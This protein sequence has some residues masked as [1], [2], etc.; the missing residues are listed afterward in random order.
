[1]KD[2]TNFVSSPS[3]PSEFDGETSSIATLTNQ[4][5]LVTVE[6]EAPPPPP[7]EPM[8]KR[9]TLYTQQTPHTQHIPGL[10]GC[11][12]RFQESGRKSVHRSTKRRKRTIADESAENVIDWWSKYYASVE[13]Q[14]VL[15]SQGPVLTRDDE[16]LCVCVSGEE[17]GRLA[18][19]AHL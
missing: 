12:T 2:Q 6:G 17:Q 13:K 10:H 9:V 5:Y 11:L 18:F 3:G 7:E 15:C 19:P 14:V 1:M 16:L 8:K 4:D